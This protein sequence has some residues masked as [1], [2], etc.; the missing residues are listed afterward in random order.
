MSLHVHAIW[1]TTLSTLHYGVKPNLL[2]PLQE[3]P[4][5]NWSTTFLKYSK[6]NCSI[7]KATHVLRQV[8]AA[9]H[10]MPQRAISVDALQASCKEDLAQN[11]SS[12]VPGSM[13]GKAHVD[14]ATDQLLHTGTDYLYQFCQLHCDIWRNST[15]LDTNRY[16]C[17]EDTA[18]C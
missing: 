10:V 2:M 14:A 5:S 18:L 3:T 1:I 4:E 17:R 6:H 7:D 8:Q 12:N 15:T 16:M 11:Q 13:H 9:A